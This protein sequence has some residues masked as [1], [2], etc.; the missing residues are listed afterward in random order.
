M[1][2]LFVKHKYLNF[3]LAVDKIYDIFELTSAGKDFLDAVKENRKSFRRLKRLEILEWLTT[4][5]AL[6]AFIKS[7]FF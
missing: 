7:F 6:A 5:V 1:C 4:V 2:E 3:S